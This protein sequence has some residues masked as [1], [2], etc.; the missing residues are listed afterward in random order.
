M[1]GN[2]PF[3]RHVFVCQGPSCSQDGQGKTLQQTFDDLLCAKDLAR[4]VKVTPCI[5]LGLCNKGPNVI[6]YP[7]N[8][9]YTRIQVSNVEEIVD[10]HLAQNQPV[11]RL[12]YKR[13]F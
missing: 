13:H 6:V 5:C 12:M 3:D 2:Y 9:V 8:I 11:E 1:P 10:G 7:D 4:K